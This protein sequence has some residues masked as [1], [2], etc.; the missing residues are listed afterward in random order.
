MTLTAWQFTYNGLSFGVGSEIGVTQIS[1][2]REMPPLRASD[3]PRLRAPG[4]YYGIDVIGART[5]GF[6]LLVV[7]QSDLETQLTNI[8]TAF[9]PLQ[10]TTSN[11]VFQLP[12]QGQ[13]RQV[14]CRC[15][16]RSTV[17]DPNYSYGY[18]T[19]QVQLVAADPRIYDVTQTTVSLNGTA[20]NSGNVESRPVVTCTSPAS[21]TTVTNTTSTGFVKLTAV[22]PNTM[23]GTVVIDAGARTITDGTN[24]RMDLLDPTSTWFTVAPGAN[25]FTVAGGG[26]ASLTF[27]NAWLQ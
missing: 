6:S 8:D 22:S 26:T 1:G 27:R 11:L 17:I 14:A 19:T 18:V 25:T 2:L 7:A 20:T 5:I 23:P 21:G 13:N 24:N 3:S 10:S 9:I 16:R 4:D 15:R 12:N